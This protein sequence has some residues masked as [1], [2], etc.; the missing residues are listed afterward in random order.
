MY[1]KQ[2]LLNLRNSPLSQLCPKNLGPVAKDLYT[3]PSEANN[4]KGGGP[5]KKKKKPKKRAKSMPPKQEL[6]NTQGKPIQFE[7][8]TQVAGLDAPRFQENYMCVGLTQQGIP[9]YQKIV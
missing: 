8:I 2:Q 4:A 7:F 3:P 6:P 9:V 1:T 5:T